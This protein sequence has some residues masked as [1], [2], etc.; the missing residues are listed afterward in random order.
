MSFYEEYSDG[1]QD[2]NVIYSIYDAVYNAL[3]VYITH[4]SNNIMIRKTE[5]FRKIPIQIMDVSSIRYQLATLLSIPSVIDLLSIGSYSL[6]SRITMWNSGSITL[7]QKI[8]ALDI[9][10]YYTTL[11]ANRGIQGEENTYVI[12]F[13]LFNSSETI[14]YYRNSDYVFQNNKL[15]LIG[16]IAVPSKDKDIVMKDI[17]VDMLT[18]ESLLGSRI[19]IDYSDAMTKNEYTELMSML[20]MA[21]LKGP[22]IKN[23]QSEIQS[24]KEFSQSSFYDLYSYDSSKK[25]LWTSLNSTLTP[26]D[27]IVSF[28]ASYLETI[29]KLNVLI[30]YLN[31]VKPSFSRLNAL[32]TTEAETEDYDSVSQVEES[33]E[34]AVMT[35]MYSELFGSETNSENLTNTDFDI[36]YVEFVSSEIYNSNIAF[37]ISS[38]LIRI[39]DGAVV[40]TYDY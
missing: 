6:S 35:Y 33:V 36:A 40:G 3:S 32:L 28:P 17:Y 4:V 18:P 8:S 13:K 5:T 22:V 23:L 9:S 26:F 34:P 14:M 15:Y 39:S 11:Y 1:K 12:D 7:P 10:G 24:I 38:R 30:R 20:T 29:D 37:D 16:S 21:S 19:G 2:F 27:F 25:H 31:I